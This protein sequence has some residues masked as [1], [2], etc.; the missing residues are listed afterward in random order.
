MTYGTERA[1]AYRLIEDALN[2]KDT[3][4]FDYET[5][6]NGNKI[7]I[8]NKKETMLASQKQDLIKEEFKIGYLKN[9]IEEKSL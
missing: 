9:Q 5:D 1:N 8:L 2:L 6:E 4:I 7:S 3:R